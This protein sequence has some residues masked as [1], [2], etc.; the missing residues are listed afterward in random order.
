MGTALLQDDTAPWRDLVLQSLAHAH[1]DIPSCA[2]HI[3]LTRWGHAMAIPRPGAHRHP[4]LLALRRLRG[5]VRCA[6]ADLAA[7][8][9]FEEAYVAGCEAAAAPLSV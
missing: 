5:R 8:S 7:Y 3:D 9:V 1:P 4:A 2:A 6:H